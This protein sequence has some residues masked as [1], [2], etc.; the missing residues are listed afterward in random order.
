VGKIR[1][2]QIDWGVFFAA[3]CGAAAAL[4]GLLFVALSI[5]L[6]RILATPYLIDRAGESIVIFLNLLFFSTLG[7]VPNQS[8]SAFGA[9]ILATSLTIW[10]FTT[11]LHVRGVR[12]RPAQATP[13]LI[14]LR[15]IQTQTATIC[16]VV[17]GVLLA[18]GRESGLF[19][20]VPATLLAYLAG[21][22][23]A[24][25]LTVEILR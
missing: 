17:A 5:N 22:G 2:T 9:E 24:W 1:V 7:M 12:N 21:I 10:L 23:N 11:A 6:Q 8:L 15:V 14:V 18:D 13:R 3:Q 19:W 25:V 16:A 20:L 4:I